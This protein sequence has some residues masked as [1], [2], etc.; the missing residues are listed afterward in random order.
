MQQEHMILLDSLWSLC[1]IQVI[2]CLSNSAQS[3]KLCL[4]SWHTTFGMKYRTLVL[5][6]AICLLA[7]P[8]DVCSEAPV[9]APED[10]CFWT[11]SLKKEITSTSSVINKKTL[12]R[13][14]STVS[15]SLSPTYWKFM[16]LISAT[17][18]LSVQFAHLASSQCCSATSPMWACTP[19][20]DEFSFHS[21]WFS[22]SANLLWGRRKKT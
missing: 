20:A 1:Q 6:V 3:I 16:F 2:W 14:G 22:S 10:I 7:V 9:D 17:R 21:C 4:Y 18:S 11:E 13:P 8:E 5:E 15:L 19:Q 12:G